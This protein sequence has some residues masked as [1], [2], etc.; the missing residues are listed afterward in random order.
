MPQRPR[1]VVTERPSQLGFDWEELRSLVYFNSHNSN[2]Y[3]G[4]SYSLF[5][6]IWKWVNQMNLK[7]LIKVFFP[8]F[9]FPSVFVCCVGFGKISVV[10]HVKY[11]GFKKCK[12][13]A[14]LLYWSTTSVCRTKVTCVIFINPKTTN[15][16]LHVENSFVVREGWKSKSKY[17]RN[18]YG[19]GQLLSVPRPATQV[20]ETEFSAGR[21]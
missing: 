12:L 18:G 11:S 1:P 8:Q 6:I 10:Q 3:I 19:E 7:C 9:H 13:G 2:C 16:E 20:G 15:T 14:G 17:Y 5:M 4:G 21:R